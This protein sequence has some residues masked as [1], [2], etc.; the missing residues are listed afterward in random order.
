VEVKIKDL[1]TRGEK[2]VSVE[3]AREWDKS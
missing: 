3:D 1:S 2:A